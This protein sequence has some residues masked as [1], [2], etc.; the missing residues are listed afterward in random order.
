MGFGD[1]PEELRGPALGPIIN[2]DYT[3]WGSILGSPYDPYVGKLP[4]KHS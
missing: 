3:V 2:E 1:V 4:V